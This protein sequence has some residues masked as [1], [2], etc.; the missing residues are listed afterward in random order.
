MR[1]REPAH[2]YLAVKEATTPPLH[3]FE[4]A[5]FDALAG[6]SIDSPAVYAYE[7]YDNVF[8]REIMQAWVL[9]GADDALVLHILNI[10]T[11]VTQAYRHLFFDVTVFRDRLDILSWVRTYPKTPSATQDG[12]AIL[13]TAVMRG[14]KALAWIYG[15]GEV[16]VDPVDV[17]RHAM[18]DAYFRG[19]SNRDHRLS[20]KEAAVTHALMNSA[21]KIAAALDKKKPS[22]AN[23]LALKLKY[24]E[25][26]TPVGQAQA[27]EELLH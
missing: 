19:L 15:R 1:Q 14:P 23:A 18:S 5:L 13:Q 9:S 24:R 16:E 4:R 8:E 22:D 7:I 2:R 21:V 25:L 20:S 27:A 26:T 12:G 6:T 10:P 3:L 11:E 17:M